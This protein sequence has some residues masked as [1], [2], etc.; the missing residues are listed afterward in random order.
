[1]YIPSTVRTAF[2][3]HLVPIRAIVRVTTRGELFAAIRQ[4]EHDAHEAR[5][6]CNDDLATRFDWRAA[7]LREAVR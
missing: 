5:A 2:G 4:I 1:M 3:P 6:A 7:A